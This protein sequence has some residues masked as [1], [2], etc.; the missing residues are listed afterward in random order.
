MIVKLPSLSFSSILVAALAACGG[1][2]DDSSRADGPGAASSSGM[3]GPVTDPSKCETSAARDLAVASDDLNGYPPYAVAECKLVYVSRSGDLL[4]RDLSTPAEIKLAPVSE[5]PRRPSIAID[6]DGTS[7]TL[8][9]VWES[10][11]ASGPVVRVRY[12]DRLS[13]VHGDFV[14]ATEPRAREHFVALTAWKGTTVADDTDVWLFDARTG[15]ARLAIGG[16]GQQR[17]ADVSGT[18]VVATDFAEDPDGHISGEG[19]LADLIV[20]DIATEAV[21]RR[22]APG[23]QAFPMLSTSGA[24]VYLSW[25]G[26]QPEPK[27]EAYELRTGPLL[28]DPASDRTIADVRYTSAEPARPALAGEMLEWIANDEA[29]ATSLYRAPADGAAPPLRVT[30]LDDLVLYAPASSSG[31]RAAFTVLAAASISGADRAPRL[32]AVDR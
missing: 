23:K 29:G 30:G 17:F 31:T 10:T 15:A 1:A 21:T 19:D 13:T 25:R 26:A 7:S 2:R 6:A 20:F 28:G 12:G 16:P 32:R 14:M 22:A 8:V 18:H 5:R 11:L 4:L 27:L 24:L 9:I 3:P